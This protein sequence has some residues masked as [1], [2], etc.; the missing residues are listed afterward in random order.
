M[1]IAVFMF[2]HFESLVFFLQHHRKVNIQCGI[3]IS[4]RGVIGIFDKASGIFVV[5]VVFYKFRIDVFQHVHASL[6]IHHRLFVAVFIGEEHRCYTGNFSNPVVIGTE[7][8]GDVYDSGT[9]FGRHV[10][11]EDYSESISFRPHP[12]Y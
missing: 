5:D 9:V 12:R 6:F 8:G 10:I 11:S 4:E 7:S 1:R 3:R 2:F